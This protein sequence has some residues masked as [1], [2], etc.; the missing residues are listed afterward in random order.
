MMQEER[1]L[2]HWYF[3]SEVWV[4]RA[5]TMPRPDIM[6]TSFLSMRPP[7]LLIVAASRHK[8]P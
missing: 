7:I 1:R 3:S 2:R 5:K 8:A 6:M 4:K